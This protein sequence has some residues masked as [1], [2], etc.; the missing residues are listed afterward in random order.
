ML[1]AFASKYGFY[2]LGAGASARIMPTT[3]ELGAKSG[4]RFINFGIYP[5]ISEEPDDVFDRIINSSLSQ[6]DPFQAALLKHIPIPAVHAL[7]LQQ[8]APPNHINR[9]DQYLVFNLCNKPSFFFNLNV[10]GLANRY[11]IGHIVVDP[12]GTVPSFIARPSFW[13]LIIAWAMEYEIQPPLIGDILL[14]SR[15]PKD[16]T[17]R[18]AYKKALK[19]F[20]LSKSLI[21]IGYSFG[22]F[23]SSRDDAE[24]FEFFCEMLR[25]YPKPVIV[26]GLNPEGIA[27]A[28][29]EAIRQRSVYSIPAYWN[30]LSRALLEVA[31]NYRCY[32]PINL[33]SLQAEICYRYNQLCISDV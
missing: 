27:A 7:V 11:C 32:N 4:Q 14:P 26:V 1:K 30:H 29:Q 28:I 21:L 17:N 19:Y 31:Y 6:F 18:I 12:H 9:I 22:T 16:I 13:D 5:A 8:L 3:S 25:M 15:E 33:C 2:V 10:D 20:P 23:S 24:T